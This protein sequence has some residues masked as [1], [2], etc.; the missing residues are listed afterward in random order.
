MNAC[1][2]ACTIH[3]GGDLWSIF[4]EGEEIVLGVGDMLIYDGVNEFHWRDKFIGNDCI[5]VMLFYLDATRKDIDE[6]KY[7]GRPLLGVPVYF[8]NRETLESDY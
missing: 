8:N 3:L 1:E 2:I 5:Q 6:Q 7:D 4:L